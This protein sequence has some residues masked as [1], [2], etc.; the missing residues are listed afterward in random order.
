MARHEKR[1]LA[2]QPVRLERHLDTKLE[3]QKTLSAKRLSFVSKD[4]RLYQKTFICIKRRSFVSEDFRLYQ[5]TFV[6]VKTF[7][8][9]NVEK[10]KPFYLCIN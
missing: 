10:E 7:W 5:K 8:P 1:L 9:K 4:F 6:R 3:T 2:W